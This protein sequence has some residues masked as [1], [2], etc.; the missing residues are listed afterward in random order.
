MYIKHSHLRKGRLSSL[1]LRPKF[2]LPP[3]TPN[4]ATPTS[5]LFLEIMR[6][7]LGYGLEELDFEFR[8]EQGIFLFS[9]LPNHLRIPPNLL[10]NGYRG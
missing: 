4:P 6:F 10:L 5:N 3:F 8:Q 1:R 7:T 9:K 2:H